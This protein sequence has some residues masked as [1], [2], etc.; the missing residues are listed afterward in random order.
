MNL[1]LESGRLGTD[2]E[3]KTTQTGKQVCRLRLAGDSGIKPKEGEQPTPVW[4]SVIAWQNLA[5]ACAATLHKGDL[6][7]VLGRQASHEYEKSG[8]K[9]RDY[10]IVAEMVAVDARTLARR[11]APADQAAANAKAALE[12]SDINLDDLPF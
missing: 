11:T 10:E 5:E 9:V 1:V 8:V 2:P 3:L 6:V 4:L 12:G 7:V